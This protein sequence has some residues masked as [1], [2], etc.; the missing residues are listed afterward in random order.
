[1]ETK[2]FKEL[3]EH[4]GHKARV[5]SH[6]QDES[7]TVCV[8]CSCGH[9]LLSV[10]HD[11]DFLTKSEKAIDCV[12]GIVSIL[13][14]DP[15]ADPQE[16]TWDAETMTDVANALGNYGFGPHAKEE[17]K[18]RCDHILDPLTV[19]LADGTT[20]TFDCTCVKCGTGGSFEFINHTAE[21]Q[22]LPEDE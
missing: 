19:R 5:V 21:I 10:K 2:S 4:V 9:D 1:M 18:P 20:R 8:E 13:W 15:E 6:I 14:P 7:G 3:M 17:Y 22:W 16:S 12:D 11:D